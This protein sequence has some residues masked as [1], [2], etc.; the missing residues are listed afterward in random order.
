MNLFFLPCILTVIPLF[1]QLVNLQFKFMMEY[2]ETMRIKFLFNPILLPLTGLYYLFCLIRH[3][4]MAYYPAQ[5]LSHHY[6][7]SVGNLALGGTGKTPIELYIT[8]LFKGKVNIITRGYHRQSPH[9]ILAYGHQITGEMKARTTGDE[10]YWLASHSPESYFSI[11]S[12][13]EKSVRVDSFPYP[14][15]IIDDAFHWFRIRQNLKICVLDAWEP[16]EDGWLFPMGRL[17]HPPIDLKYADIIWLS[18]ANLITAE[19]LQTWK[20]KLHKLNPR[21]RL[22]CSGYYPDCLL[23]STG[24][25]FELDILKDKRILAVSGIAKPNPFY[26]NLLTFDLLEMVTLGF[27][28]H[29]PYTQAEIDQLELIIRHDQIDYIVTTA[30]DMVKLQEF[31]ISIPLLAL[32]MKVKTF[33][34]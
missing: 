4:L 26:Q 21:A 1:F 14:V 3:Y 23:S 32:Q 13:K 34:D 30:K 16:M 31:K 28:D 9:P 17:R 6:L 27:P 5:T 19:E 20:I 12:H 18:R 7:I 33:N 29:Y 10:A 2:H 25:I 8:Q 11:S 22:I 15:T 24:Q